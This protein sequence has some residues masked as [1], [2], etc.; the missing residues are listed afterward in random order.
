MMHN[1]PS[2]SIV[3]CCWCMLRSRGEDLGSVSNLGSGAD[4]DAVNQDVIIVLAQKL[5]A[6]QHE[7]LCP[8]QTCREE[9]EE[10]KREMNIWEQQKQRAKP[11]EEQIHFYVWCACIASS[12]PE[13]VKEAIVLPISPF[14]KKE[15]ESV[16]Q[17]GSCEPDEKILHI[18]YKRYGCGEPLDTVVLCKGYNSSVFY[19]TITER[20]RYMAELIWTEGTRIVFEKEKQR[21]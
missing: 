9:V 18:A 11:P 3:I 17:D 15:L 5:A 20:Y 12:S 14:H 10:E 7:E 6:T 8:P 13:I 21:Q 16:S 4:Y 2:S 1:L 19:H